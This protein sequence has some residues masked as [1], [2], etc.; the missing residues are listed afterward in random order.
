ML[1]EEVF[2]LVQTSRLSVLTFLGPIVVGPEA[3]HLIADR[4]QEKG[5][6]RAR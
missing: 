2:I 3:P 6:A 4:K 1:R 5:R